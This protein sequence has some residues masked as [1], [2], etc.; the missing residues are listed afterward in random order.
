MPFLKCLNEKCGY[1]WSYTGLRP[2]LPE[3]GFRKII[4]PRCAHFHVRIY[5]ITPEQYTEYLIAQQKK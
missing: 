4:C 1:C 5:S 3:G 2:E